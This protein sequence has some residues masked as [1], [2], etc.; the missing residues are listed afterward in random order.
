MTMKKGGNTQTAKIQNWVDKVRLVPMLCFF[1]KF[2][3]KPTKSYC[4]LKSY[5]S[6]SRKIEPMQELRNSK[7][8]PHQNFSLV[9]AIYSPWKIIS[10]HLLLCWSIKTMLQH[11]KKL[12]AFI[13]PFEKW[14]NAKFG[15]MLVEEQCNNIAL[16]VGYIPL[17]PKMKKKK[18]EELWEKDMG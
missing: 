17:N 1:W 9:S 3:K 2:E 5:T 7:R 14:L 11:I 16:L 13:D 12:F 4:Q 18:M 15:K 8:Y 10:L 6:T